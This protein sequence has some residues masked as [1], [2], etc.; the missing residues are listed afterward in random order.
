M[1][2]R[3][4]AF[5]AERGVVDQAVDRPEILA[6]AFD[7]VGDLLDLGKVERNEME[8]TAPCAP[9]LLDRRCELIAFLSARPPITE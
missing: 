7:Q 3:Q 4:H 2:G 1:H 8:R 6:Q 9:C 5:R